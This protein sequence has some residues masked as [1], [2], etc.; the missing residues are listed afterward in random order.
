MKLT[1]LQKNCIE[2]LAAAD[3]RGKNTMLGLLL[4]EGIRFFYCENDPFNSIEMGKLNSTAIKE[5][6]EDLQNEIQSKLN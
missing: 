1:K 4:I 3:V 5:M 2:K 6:I